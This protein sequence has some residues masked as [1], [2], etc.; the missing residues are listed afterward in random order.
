MSTGHLNTTTSAVENSIASDWTSKADS[1]LATP[2]ASPEA[3]RSADVGQLSSSDCDADRD[4]DA[5]VGGLLNFADVPSQL[6]HLPFNPCSTDPSSTQA[7][8]P[9]SSL[10]TSFSSAI[11]T[12]T[13][14]FASPAPSTSTT[15][16]TPGASAAVTP[17][18]NKTTTTP[19]ALLPFPTPTSPLPSSSIR[20]TS[21]GLAA[22]LKALGFGSAK[23]NTPPTTP[24]HDNIGRLDEEHLRQLDEKHQAGS[25]RSVIARR[26]RPWKGVGASSSP[27]PVAQEPLIEIPPFK[28]DDTES[29]ATLLPEIRTPEPLD[30]DTQK[31]RLP[32]HTNGNGTKVTLET[33]REHLE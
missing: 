2:A 21:P 12:T 32:D 9:N 18:T 13:T 19:A 25:I 20:K 33:R 4:H 5:P 26:G 30:M 28:V 27:K 15:D 16:T 7:P 29:I 11:D 14:S 31:Y 17:A 8:D 23:P 3:N 6:S 1:F 22:R 10:L 24:L